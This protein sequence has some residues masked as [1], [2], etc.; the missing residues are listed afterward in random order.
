MQRT[1]NAVQ[2]STPRPQQSAVPPAGPQPIDPSMFKFI[3][4][5]LPR[6]GGWADTQAQ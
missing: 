2:T 6:D 3:A 4:G 5:G 1:T